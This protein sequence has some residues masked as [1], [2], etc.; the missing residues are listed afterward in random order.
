MLTEDISKTDQTLE[1]DNPGF[2]AAPTNQS[3][4]ASNGT[5]PTY[6]ESPAEL[7]TK[8]NVSKLTVVVDPRGMSSHAVS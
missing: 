8:K 6:I 5:N 1:N 4:E 3:T 7:N 2:D